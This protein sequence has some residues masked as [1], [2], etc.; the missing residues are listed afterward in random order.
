MTWYVYMVRCCD[1]S[2]YTGV[3]TDVQRR[4]K[5]HN[6]EFKNKGA[7]YTKTRR[8]V[9]LVYSKRKRNRS[10]A[11][12]EEAKIKNLSRVEKLLLVTVS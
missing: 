9:A 5:E 4:I 11:Q 3:A 7:K 2:L 12:I 6:G 8:P 1:D 10:Y